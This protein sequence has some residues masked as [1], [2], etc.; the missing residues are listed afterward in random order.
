MLVLRSFGPRALAV[1]FVGRGV[2][3]ALSSNPPPP[4]ISVLFTLQVTYSSQEKPIVQCWMRA[5]R[6]RSLTLKALA[7]GTSSS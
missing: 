5:S 2:H 6:N 1:G 7:A 4:H 3:K